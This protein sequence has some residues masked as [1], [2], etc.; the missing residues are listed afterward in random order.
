[1]P[2]DVALQ[3]QHA[4]DL[5]APGLLQDPAE[6]VD[7]E[8]LGE[9][10]GAESGDALDV[11]GVADDVQRQALAG[12]GLGDVEPGA[13]VQHDRAPPA[14]T[15]CWAAAGSC[16]HLV[17]PAHPAG[18][19]EVQH[20]VGAPRRRCRGTCRAGVTPSTIAAGQRRDRRVVGL[21]AA[22]RGDV[23]AHDRTAVQA[24]G[25]VLRP[26]LRP[27]AAPAR[28]QRYCGNPALRPSLV[29]HAPHPLPL[30]PG[31]RAARGGRLAVAPG[32]RRTPRDPEPGQPG[33]R[34]PRRPEHHRR[35]RPDHRA[36][37]P[38]AEP[39]VPDRAHPRRHGRP[40]LAADGAGR[41][42]DP[43]RVDPRPRRSRAGTSATRC[44]RAGTAP[45]A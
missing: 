37:R 19:R 36:R 1:M 20:E 5:R 12:P 41:L 42:A 35:L 3:T 13:V 34:R 21:Q 18:A 44:A 10:I 33:V 23:D 39:G 17:L 2:G 29:R 26:A 7:G 6:H 32:R 4:L 16:R 25:Q 11:G 15:C 43:A 22:E 38:A 14:A 31:P 24:P 40:D 30:A 9:R 45:A 28:G 8:V 27:R